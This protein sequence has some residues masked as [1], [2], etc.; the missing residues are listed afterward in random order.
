MLHI[1]RSAALTLLAVAFTLVINVV[2][3][4][5][6]LHRNDVAKMV[7]G[8]KDINVTF[9]GMLHSVAAL[10]SPPLRELMP[11]KAMCCRSSSCRNR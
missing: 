11:K 7:Y 10:I 8:K 9:A 3:N 5:T 6:F 4:L 1:G 2:N